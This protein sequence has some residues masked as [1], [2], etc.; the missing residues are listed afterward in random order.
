MIV[1]VCLYKHVIHLQFA[2]TF[3]FGAGSS[4]EK[5]RAG[6]PAGICGAV[7]LYSVTLLLNVAFGVKMMLVG[8]R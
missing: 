7:C 8:F 5:L 6:K 2:H 3:E 4:F 1:H